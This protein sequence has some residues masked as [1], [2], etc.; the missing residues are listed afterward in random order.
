ML[1]DSPLGPPL[2]EP[3][4]RRREEAAALFSRRRSGPTGRQDWS[5]P[6]LMGDFLAARLG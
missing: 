6:V 4:G 3:G 2:D 1:A 5:A